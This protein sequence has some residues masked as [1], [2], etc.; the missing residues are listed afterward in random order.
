MTPSLA[1]L[2]L[3]AAG[4]GYLL[5]PNQIRYEVSSAITAATCGGIPRLT[6]DQGLE[7]IEEFLALGLTSIGDNEVIH[8]AYR[9]V[10]QY[11]IAFYDALYLAYA[12]TLNCSLVTADYRFYQR[13]RPL[14]SALWIGEYGTII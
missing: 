7:A 3:F 9:L 5:A 2:E 13:I 6:A 8:S 12:I 10:H 1:L 11:D 14:P 4:D